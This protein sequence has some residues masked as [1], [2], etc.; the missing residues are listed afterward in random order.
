[1]SVCVCVCV[2]VC[3]CVWCWGWSDF[4]S[5]IYSQVLQDCLVVVALVVVHRHDATAN[6]DVKTCVRWNRPRHYATPIPVRSPEVYYLPYHIGNSY[7]PKW[8]STLNLI[9]LHGLLHRLF[10]LSQLGGVNLRT[11]PAIWHSMA[12]DVGCETAMF[13]FD[14]SKCHDCNRRANL[15]ATSNEFDYY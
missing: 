10:Y 15:I 7:H 14:G 9:G 13:L 4:L 6:Y 12:S 3:E 11:T 2:C 5:Q 8:L 1:M